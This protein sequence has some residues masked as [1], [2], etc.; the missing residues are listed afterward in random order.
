VSLADKALIMIFK[1]FV[2]ADLNRSILGNIDVNKTP[3]RSGIYMQ[4]FC[5]FLLI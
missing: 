2:G 5:H 4:N 3:V 1:I